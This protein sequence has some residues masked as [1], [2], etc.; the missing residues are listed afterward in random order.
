MYRLI[1]AA[2]LLIMAPG[3][4]FALGMTVGGS[5]E[6]RFL[7][8][9]VQAPKRVDG[10]FVYTVPADFNPPGIHQN[11]LQEI[12]AAA[13]A[14][15]FPFYVVIVDSIP[16]LTDVQ[17]AEA[18]HREYTENGIELQMAYAVDKIVEEWAS[19]GSYDASRTS[20]FLLSYHPRQYRMLA[21]AKWK[22]DLG[23][24]RDKLDP[25]LNLFKRSAMGS[26]KDPKAGIINLMGTFDEF[27]F[28]Q[29]DPGRI[30]A[31]AEAAAKALEAERA[32]AIAI[33]LATAKGRLGNLQ[34]QSKELLKGDKSHLPDTKAL[35][36]ALRHVDTLS[37]ADYQR[38]G[39]VNAEADS[40]LA[41]YTPVKVYYDA[42]EQKAL[43]DAFWYY[44]SWFMFLCGIC[45]LI[46]MYLM[47]RSRYLSLIQEFAQDYKDWD[48][49]VKAA[50]GRYVD[51]YSNRDNIIGLH[52]TEGKT[53]TLWDALSFEIDDIW[54]GVKAIE[55]HIAECKTLAA[56]AN[57]F[58]I[59]PL[60][61]AI[62]NLDRA[63][64]FDTGQ[65]NVDEL[66]GRDT[67]TIRVV[68][69]SFAQTLQQRFKNNQESWDRIK[70]AADI[71]MPDQCASNLF[72]HLPLT[73]LMR[74]AAKL[75]IPDAWYNDHPLAGDDA[76]DAA[77]WEAAD[78][79]RVKDPIAYLDAIE[80]LKAQERKVI[81]R[82]DRLVNAL[83]LI[84]PV[85]VDSLPAFE[86]AFDA[87]DD[88]AITLSNARDTE[89]RLA[90][91]LES[92]AETKAVDAIDA[93]VADIVALYTK[94]KAQVGTITAA[95]KDANDAV[96]A[97][98]AA[99]PKKLGVDAAICVKSA[100]RIHLNIEVANTNLKSGD[101]LTAQGRIAFLRANEALK[102]GRHLEA[103]RKASSASTLYANAR[104]AYEKAV[105]YCGELDRS[106]AAFEAKVGKMASIREEHMRRV[107]QYH[108]API[109]LKSYSAPSVSNVMDYSIALSALSA[110]ESAWE[111]ESRQV[112]SA[113]EAEQARQR[114][115]RDEQDRRERQAIA[116]A[117]EAAAS[118]RRAASY[119]S[120]SSGYTSYSSGGS[121]SGGGSCGG[122][123]SDSGG[124]GW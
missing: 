112:Q 6:D 109:R 41:A 78:S 60:L 123:G 33:A 74:A 25:Y 72:P 37:D 5:P 70:R 113:Y 62:S 35:E 88:P 94:V 51:A 81:A 49:K 20:A 93:Y 76:S 26:S 121:D 71:R 55:S 108:G 24:R 22:L 8:G 119:S 19:Y 27:V 18:R 85:K 36:A 4:T 118:A 66:F 44:F 40:L 13:K 59:T 79:L 103:L 63:F 57:V 101:D 30:K 98:D 43:V 3:T 90:G 42:K 89:H 38:A 120:Y 84:K 9:P 39:P 17:V 56:K 95:V 46:G 80:A 96:R 77:V 10:Q 69:S 116:A 65:V 32:Q 47:R 99:Y 1:L 100:A 104:K 2:F 52:D 97:A 64:T 105:S 58:Y 73:N 7:A 92:K 31:R 117:A 75:G 21:G 48:D 61:D 16:D 83:S 50:A 82:H 102:S 107:K 124:G 122:G 34:L 106:R 11:G 114:A 53:K 15:H 12:Q 86:S 111:R 110:Q 14:L 29:T 23:I 91:L 68:P 67:K 115:E 28:D 87:S 54:V 45:F